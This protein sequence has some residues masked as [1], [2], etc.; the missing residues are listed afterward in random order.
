MNKIKSLV[1]A[2]AA[3]MALSSCGD[4][5]YIE[6]KTFVSEENF[7]N[8]KADVDQM[9]AGVYVK[10]QSSAF[11][12]RLIMWGETRSDNIGEGRN[13]TGNLDVYRVLKEDLKSN[14]KFA[15]WTALYAVIGQCNIIID[16]CGVVAEKD[17]TF[18]E[19]DVKA[20]RAEMA[21][22]RDLCYFYLVRTFKDVPYYTYAIQADADIQ[23][24]PAVDGDSIIRCLIADLD[25]VA[26]HAMKV[27]PEDNT[28]R[29]N[30]TRNRMTQAGIYALLADLCL[31]DGQYQ[32]CVDYSQKVIDFKMKEYRD[33]YSKMKGSGNGYI[34]LF[35]HTDDNYT[36]GFPLYRCFGSRET[37]FGNDFSEIFGSYG[38]SFESIFEL[39]F[40]AD[41][42]NSSYNEN[43]ACGSYY[44]SYKSNSNEGKGLLGLPQKLLDNLSTPATGSMSSKVAKTTLCFDHALDVRQ[45]VNVNTDETY[46]AGYV[47]KYVFY[48]ASVEQSNGKWRTSYSSTSTDNRNWIFY[49][50]TDVMLMQAEAL[51]QLGNINVEKDD[52]GEIVSTTLDDNLKHAFYLMWAVNR[53]SIMTSNLTTAHGNEL[54]MDMCTSKA[55]MLT[56]CLKER[57]REL[58]FEGKRWFDLV[59]QCHHEG[60]TNFVRQYVTSKVSESSKSLF[61][62]YESLFWPYYKNE[63]RNNDALSQ[64]PFY[65]NDDDEDNYKLNN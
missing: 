59:R 35:K 39:A 47:G 64:K 60:N 13:T 5:L 38:S 28:T 52:Q 15:D 30:T 17:P 26:P 24:M 40:T 42:A 56:I 34:E 45:Y 10:M 49:R 14:N 22:I 50:L 20:T 55:D 32:R 9:V 51:I 31:W 1:L 21:A 54:K 43:S 57:R 2:G 16:R 8:E 11:I 7:W 23:P 44:G 27:F 63:L 6:P 61:L 65:G 29:Y 18:T 48:D 19:S 62:N 36:E 3:S 4:F 33:E 41:G 37:E 12:E 46:T 58:M 25:T 53:R